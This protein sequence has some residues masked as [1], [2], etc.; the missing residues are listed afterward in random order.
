MS[1]KAYKFRIY[2]NKEQKELFQKTFGCTRYIYNMYLAVRKD[3]Y[4]LEG[5]SVSYGETSSMLTN[6]KQQ[7]SFLKEIDSIALQQTLRHLDEAFKKFFKGLSGY[8]QF[9]SKKKTKK[10]Y[11]TINING[12]IKL[13]GKYIRLPKVGY[14]R[15]RQHRDIPD[16]HIIKSAT[17]SQ[18]PTGKYYISVLT[19]YESQ[20]TEHTDTNKAIGLDFSMHGL[21]VSSEGIHAD[22]PCYYLETMNKLEREQK[23]LSKLY[24]KDKNIQSHN[25]Y[26]QRRKVAVLHEKISNQRMDFL[27]KLSHHLVQQYDYICIEDLSITDMMQ[28]MDT[29]NFSRKI[30]DYGWN[31]FTSMLQYKADMYGK[32]LIRIDRYFP[33]SQTCH[34]C[35]AVNTAVKDLSIREWDCPSCGHHHDR[36]MN[37]A[38]NIKNEGLRLALL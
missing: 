29:S 34:I 15:L 8:P 35:G 13:S 11:T 25:Y 1:N 10:V 17:I 36:D 14:V 22:M 7:D 38:I 37:A 23:K 26:K 2:P 28:G 19:E 12:S 24:R 6:Q 16:N 31:A 4:Q 21:Y 18:S 9:K 32:H 33:S 3:A 20:V 30:T 5:R 27:H